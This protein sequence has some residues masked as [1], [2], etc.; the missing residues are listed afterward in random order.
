MLEMIKEFS[1]PQTAL[2]ILFCLVRKTHIKRSTCA[3]DAPYP[4]VWQGT[5]TLSMFYWGV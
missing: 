2:S 3:L 1:Y 4:T 5:S